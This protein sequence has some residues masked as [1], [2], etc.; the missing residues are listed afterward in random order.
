MKF[1]QVYWKTVP[2]KI[3][4]CGFIYSK[5]LTI[6]LRYITE[7]LENDTI[8]NDKKHKESEDN[9]DPHWTFDLYMESQMTLQGWIIYST[10]FLVHACDLLPF[11]WSKVMLLNVPYTIVSNTKLAGLR[12]ILSIYKLCWFGIKK[13][14]VIWCLKYHLLFC[15]SCIL[16]RK[17]LIHFTE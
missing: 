14:C 2:R 8:D 4:W 15:L 13:L 7:E 6:I 16:I 3:C 1:Q 11:T 12:A 5:T 10:L 9:K 17:C